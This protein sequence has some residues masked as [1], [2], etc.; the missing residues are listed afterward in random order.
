MRTNH[1][2][3]SQA[4][5]KKSLA[6]SKTNPT[7]R[8]IRN[9]AAVYK[10]VFR[11]YLSVISTV[12]INST[13]KEWNRLSAS[14]AYHAANKSDPGRYADYIEVLTAHMTSATILAKEQVLELRRSKKL[15]EFRLA[16][17]KIDE[18]LASQKEQDDMIEELQKLATQF[19]GSPNDTALKSQIAVL[20]SNL[21]T[22]AKEN[23][24]RMAEQ[25]ELQY[26]ERQR[27]RAKA[28]TLIDT[29]V[30]DLQKS[31]GLQY[32]TSVDSTDSESQLRKDLEERRDDTIAGPITTTGSDILAS[33]TVNDARADASEDLGDDVESYTFV[34]VDDDRTTAICLELNGRTFAANDP[35]VQRYQPPLHYN[36]RSYLATNL[37][38]MQDN[39]EIDTDK[40]VLSKAAQNAITLSEVDGL[41]ADIA[42]AAGRS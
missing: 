4:K 23:N 36:C 1:L 6:E 15:S 30:G 13:M 5:K 21:Y 34:A 37:R 19:Q 12:L 22:N 2:R 18:I 16:Q 35:D 26:S 40:L 38:S 28:Q 20:R 24:A 7:S 29:Q 32:Q 27:L 14:R 8:L 42:R 3:L 17:S 41:Y 11:A 25:S 31:I 39:P 10:D 9:T 33:Q